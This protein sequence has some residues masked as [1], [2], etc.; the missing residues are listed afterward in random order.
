[1]LA[2]AKRAWTVA[3]SILGISLQAVAQ[4][5]R[6]TAEFTAEFSAGTVLAATGGDYYSRSGGAFT[7]FLGA[8]TGANPTRSQVLGVNLSIV[9]DPGAGDDCVLAPDGGCL[10]KFPLLFGLGVEGGWTAGSDYTGTLRLGVGGYWNMKSDGGSGVALQSQADIAAGPIALV[11]RGIA[12]PNFQRHTV[13][14][15]TL[16]LGMRWN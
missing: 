9:G 14:I 3:V 1:M 2:S 15:A 7:T 11:L 5:S 13:F 4:P 6:A 10:P 8:R 16:T 12:L